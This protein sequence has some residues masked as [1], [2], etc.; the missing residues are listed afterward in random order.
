M[1]IQN[2]APE[3]GWSI[4][5]ILVSSGPHHDTWERGQLG[6][7][8][9][10]CTTEKCTGSRCVACF[11]LW[12]HHWLHQQ[13][14]N[15]SGSNAES[16]QTLRVTSPVLLSTSRCSQTPLELSNVLS[17]SARAFSG[18]YEIW[19]IGWPNFELLRPLRRSPRDFEGS[20]D[21][22][23]AQRETWCRIPIAVVLTL[24]QGIPSLLQSQDSLHHNMACII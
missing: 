19:L 9:E 13:N 8:L 6:S 2:Q 24:P 18:Y 3:W 1:T 14:V 21:C 11:Q 7:R 22:C 12:I 4:P 10:I 20:R 5:S 23:A 15:R 16:S 17:D